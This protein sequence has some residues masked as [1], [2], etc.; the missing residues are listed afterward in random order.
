[1]VNNDLEKNE[2]FH[3]MSWI[4]SDSGAKDFQAFQHDS[5]FLMYKSIIVASVYIA[6]YNSFSPED[7]KDVLWL[8]TRSLQY[9]FGLDHVYHI[10]EERLLVEMISTDYNQFETRMHEFQQQ[11]NQ[12]KKGD[13]TLDVDIH[14]GYVY[15][16]PVEKD[17]IE[18]MIQIVRSL[19]D[20]SEIQKADYLDYDD[21]S[22]DHAEKYYRTSRVD[23]ITG[24][25]KK[26][27]FIDLS[28]KAMQRLYDKKAVKP[29]SIAVIYVNLLNFKLFN[30]KYGYVKGNQ[31]LSDLANLLRSIYPGC[32][33][34]RFESDHFYILS[35]TRDFEDDIDSIRKGLK[36]Y[37]RNVII[38]VRA[39]V[40]FLPADK[41]SNMIHYCDNAKI[42]ADRIRHANIPLRYFKNTFEGEAVRE[43][44]IVE[45]FMTA[46]DKG[47]I[48]LYY[49]PVVRTITGS[50]CSMEVLAR[51]D[52]PKY[53]LLSP[54]VFIGVLEEY[55][56][57]HHLDVYIIENICRTYHERVEN[58]QEVVP[59]SFNLSRLDFEMTP[60]VDII[61]EKVEKYHVPKSALYVEITESVMANNTD[62]M[63]DQIRQIHEAG[64]KV[65]MDDFGSDYSSL[66]TL[67]EYEFDELK[68]DMK[69]LSKFNP[70]S[71]RII[72]SIVDMSK[73]LD[74]Q[75][76]AEGVETKDQYEFLKEIG[77]E[78]VQG[79]Y[80]SKPL[81]WDEL[82]TLLNKKDISFEDSS[83]TAFYDALG[84][85]NMLNVHPLDSSHD[86]YMSELSLGEFIYE[87]NQIRYV[88]ANKTFIKILKSFGINDIASLEK[89]VNSSDAKDINHIKDIYEHLN[90]DSKV[91]NFNFFYGNCD[92]FCELKQVYTDGV[93]RAFVIHLENITA[94]IKENQSLYFSFED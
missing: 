84:S 69:F 59:L 47:W 33:I 46:L 34:S 79:Y 66:N 41:L 90:N 56:L 12:F 2:I 88:A 16:C 5:N 51:W 25:I 27:D 86:N 63:K 54:G 31:L 45:N 57:I 4:Y 72:T 1:M 89:L 21:V 40:C 50:V 74:I 32:M 87:N 94:A 91:L 28:T 18:R 19:T 22:I 42:S 82:E 53:G 85:V 43:K 76:L 14:I 35:R 80:F 49:Q 23:K 29:K 71:R 20:S 3:K 15:G 26:S 73:N 44:Y 55:H 30:D 7:Q 11:S 48:K 52:D 65:W 61:Q 38:D 67:K 13:R 24:L 37:S 68:I 10:V 64:F 93:Q 78:K 62:F 58:H 75:T 8:V 81:P 9:Y 92:G 83:N 39:G 70:K 17:D 6:N 77:C 36:D 60:I